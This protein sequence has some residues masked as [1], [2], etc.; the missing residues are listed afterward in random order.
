ME[1][2]VVMTMLNDIRKHRPP[3]YLFDEW[4]HWM[5]A[6]AQCLLALP[7][8]PWQQ[9]AASVLVAGDIMQAYPGLSMPMAYTAVQEAIQKAAVVKS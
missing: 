3:M 6:I 4:Q 7:C 1:T 2:D 5:H 8:T 9:W